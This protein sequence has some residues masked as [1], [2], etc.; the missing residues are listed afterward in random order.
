MK[1]TFSLHRFGLLLRHYTMSDFKRHL[2]GPVGLY[3]GLLVIY[4][5][6]YYVPSS[7]GLQH[8]MTEI[9]LTH[10]ATGITVLMAFCSFFVYI[11]SSF[12]GLHTRQKRTAFL[13][14]PATTMEKYLSCIV[15]AFLNWFVAINLAVVCADLTRMAFF[16]LMGH[17]F[18][19][20]LPSFYA[21]PGDFVSIT[22]E[23]AKHEFVG[24]TLLLLSTV[25]VVCVFSTT[26]FILV[27]AAFRRY[28]ILIGLLLLQ[29][30]QILVGLPLTAFG[31]TTDTILTVDLVVYPLLTV[32]A[33]WWSYRL[34]SR[35][36]V[37]R[38]KFLPL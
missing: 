6:V 8:G 27:S 3:F 17:G 25:I 18:E 26:F 20:I 12:A 35:I 37:I 28:A 4:L 14:L 23:A 11:A 38:H 1:N 13:I 15:F 7:R 36:E 5:M 33:I 30:L 10:M 2:R 16:P 24:F 34:F 31:V 21:T 9:E 22:I 29:G 32:A 19:S